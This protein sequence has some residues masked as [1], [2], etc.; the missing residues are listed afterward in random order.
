MEIWDEF[1]DLRDTFQVVAFHDTKAND[2]DELDAKLQPIVE[3]RWR[4]RALPFP[5]LLDSS[6]ETL[7]T[8]GVRGFPTTILIDPEGIVVSDGSEKR[9]RQVLEEMK[10][11]R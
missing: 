11:D 9:L 4:G 2:F 8:Y 10:D 7:K 6:G 5:I 3:S 1:E